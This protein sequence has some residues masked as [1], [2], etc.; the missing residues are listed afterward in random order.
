MHYFLTGLAVGLAVGLPAG[1]Y[2]WY[3]WG[4]RVKNAEA[5]V[6]QDIRNF[7]GGAK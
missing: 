4:T 1:M 5:Q 7:K 2:L 6:S 3:R